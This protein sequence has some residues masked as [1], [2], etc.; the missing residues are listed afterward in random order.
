MM[1]TGEEAA[2]N[3][4]PPSQPS[5]RRWMPLTLLA[6]S[7]GIAVVDTFLSEGRQQPLPVLLGCTLLA[8]AWTWLVHP[9]V[10]D[11]PIV[12]MAVRMLLTAVLVGLNPWFGIYTWYAYVESP[13]YLPERLIYPALGSVA[14]IASASY[15]GG[16]PTTPVL[17]VVWLVL[18]AGS[19]ALVRFVTVAVVKAR[20]Q[21]LERNRMFEEVTIA[22]QRLEEALAENRGLQSQLVTQAREAGALDERARLAGEI[23]DTLAQALTGIIRQLEA[24]ERGGELADRGRPHVDLAAELARDGLAEARRSLRALRPRQLEGATLPDA[25]ADVARRT[26]LPV[27]VDVTG[28]V[29]ALP[30]DQEVVLLRVVQEALANVAKH[31]E[32]GRVGVTL[33]YFADAVVLDV[34]DD[35][36]GFDPG[37][38]GVRPDG[39]GM[40]LGGMRERLARIDGSLVVESAPGEGTALVA[41]LPCAVPADAS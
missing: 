23:H 12:Y 33:S 21:E 40:G 37:T 5:L 35:G 8:V 6:A 7:A 39:T 1:T 16:Y 30:P 29:R 19:F 31:A 26:G 27:E 38:V 17:I 15:I 9:S 4:L 3:D 25:I 14:L 22:N 41:T 11:L 32:A 34:R 20:E 13:N 2:V 24:A 10:R 36:V 18:S 28:A